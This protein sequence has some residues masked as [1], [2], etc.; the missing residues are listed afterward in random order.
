MTSERK[1][2]LLSELF[3]LH[4][5]GIKPGLETISKLCAY[6]GNPQRKF[7]SIH[8]AGT[9]GKGSVC[10]LTSSALVEHGFRTGL[11]TSPHILDFNERI[12]INGQ[13]ISDEAICEL[14]ES[15]LEKGLQLGATFFEITTA[16]AFRYFAEMGVDIAVIEVGMGGRLDA[17]NILQPLSTAITSIDFDHMAYLGNTLEKIAREK[18]G[19]IKPFTPCVIGEPRPELRSIF[20]EFDSGDS[21]Q[22][23]FLDDVVQLEEV[24]YRDD[25]S[26]NLTFS[27]RGT[28]HQNWNVPLSGTHQT[29]NILT[30]YTL[31]NSLPATVA[32]HTLNTTHIRSGF[33]KVHEHSGL[34][35]RTE[36]LSLPDSVPII[37]D[38]GHNEACLRALR[39]SLEVHGYGSTEWNVIF[40]VMSDK[41]IVDMIKELFPVAKEFLFCAPSIDRAASAEEIQRLYEHEFLPLQQISTNSQ[42]SCP[43]SQTFSG[44][45]HAIEYALERAHSAREPFLIVG[46]FYLAEEALRALNKHSVAS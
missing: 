39:V 17:T 31:L 22:L 16:M 25:F 15:A 19:I 20:S 36:V 41:N 14:T 7:E 1:Q 42:F 23:L 32:Q 4:R 38:V 13:M 30:A 28:L 3:S 8:V 12:R 37:L 21:S 2:Q 35:G 29:R 5:F 27:Y 34:R 6:F 11:Y 24:H 26:Q 45:A 9:N 44:V 46:S 40:G 43:R 33:Q 10:S 18:A